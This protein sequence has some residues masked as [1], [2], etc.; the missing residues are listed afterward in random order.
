[1]FIS[2]L[3]NKRKYLLTVVSIIF[4]TFLYLNSGFRY[5]IFILFSSLILYLLAKT[6]LKANIKLNFSILAIFFILIF[7][8]IIEQ[9][10]SYGVGFNLDSL[11]FTN[12]FIGNF[13][14]TAESSV[15]I[16]TSGVINAIPEKLP[17][18]NFYPL[19]KA[20][21]HPLPSGFFDKNAGDYLFNITN[22]V[23]GFRNIHQGA[24]YLNYAEYYLMFGWFGIFIFSF[25]LGHI[26]KRFWLWINLHQNEPLALLLYVLNVSYIFSIITRGYLPQQ[27]H[28]YFFIVF[29]VNAIY[30]LSLR[31]NLRI[32]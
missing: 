18:Q 26:F 15:F 16:T 7:M 25:L 3:Q 21:M 31:R 28:L 32:Y 29:P 1:M 2:T 22:A 19:I 30:F 27:L 12:N 10:R 5:R 8:I 6:K 24:A 13:F 11:N 17:F 14:N 20:I 4:S 9:I 23:Y